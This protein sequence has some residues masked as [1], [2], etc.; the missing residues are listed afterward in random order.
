MPD[1]SESPNPGTAIATLA[2]AV[3]LAVR[4][5]TGTFSSYVEVLALGLA[6]AALVTSYVLCRSSCVEGRVLA[7][8][9]AVGAGVG[10]LL[11]T[12]VGSPGE[13]ARPVGWVDVAVLALAAVIPTTVVL[14]RRR[15]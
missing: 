14:E 5:L 3:V 11:A 10:V 12:T 8:L 13:P 7:V 9:V 15:K 2:L 4:V 6:A 1:E